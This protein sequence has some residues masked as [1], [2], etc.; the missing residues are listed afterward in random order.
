MNPNDPDKLEAAISRAL[1]S[2]PDRQAPSRLEGRVLM[3]LNRRAAL[4]WWRKSFAHWPTSIRV[5]FFVGSAVA[6]AVV[7]VGLV[8][9]GASNGAEQ[10]ATGFAGRFAWVT[11]SRNIAEAIGS[12][13]LLVM[14]TIPPVWLYSAAGTVAFCY[15]ALG[16]LGAAFYRTLS[17]GRP[18]T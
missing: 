3:E 8:Q 16:A 15:A 7:V 17:F 14:R 4:P 10:L 2:I 9:L 18:S 11:T 6:A 1:R 12:K 13:F 5:I